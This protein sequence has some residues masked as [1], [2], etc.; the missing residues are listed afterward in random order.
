M[1]AVRGAAIGGV[2]G[3]V[4]SHDHYAG[5][6]L[7]DAMSF[8]EHAENVFHF[9]DHVDEADFVEG[10]AGEWRARPIAEHVG[11][12]CG[13]HIDADGARIFFS[14]AANVEDAWFGVS[15]HRRMYVPGL[16]GLRRSFLAA[17]DPH[18]G[19]PLARGVEHLES[20][21]FAL[22]HG[23][24]GTDG[25]A[26]PGVEVAQADE[27]DLQ[28]RRFLVRAAIRK[29]GFEHE[30]AEGQRPEAFHVQAKNSARAQD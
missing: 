9:F 27:R 4:R 11:L 22:L 14:A 13:A 7:C 1:P 30:A 5:A 3:V 20:S 25:T 24:V 10:A 28:S 26:L 29:S 23:F 12:A 19:R 2:I 15:W 21:R 6:G 8:G 17:S 18:H 16:W